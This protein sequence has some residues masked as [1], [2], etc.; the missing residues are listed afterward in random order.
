M[1]QVQNPANAPQN[2]GDEAM[3]MDMVWKGAAARARI[4]YALAA[5]THEKGM[6]IILEAFDILG[7]DPR[8]KKAIAEARP[9]VGR[10]VYDLAV[11]LTAG[12][13]EWMY[14]FDGSED[15]HRAA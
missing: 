11:G 9:E 1:A 13:P 12:S 7:I 6:A 4:M 15:L 14:W 2:P 3:A 10:F 8:I 5:E